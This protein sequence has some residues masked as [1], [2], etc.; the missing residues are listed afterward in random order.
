MKPGVSENVYIFEQSKELDK[1]RILL[2]MKENEAVLLF[3]SKALLVGCAL[4]LT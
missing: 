4:H 1:E 2:C 3:K